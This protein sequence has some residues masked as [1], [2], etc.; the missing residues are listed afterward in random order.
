MVK[1]GIQS[2][3]SLVG[4]TAW[5]ER[6]QTIAERISKPTRS[7]KLAATRFAAECAIEKARRGLPLS[8]AD[9]AFVDLATRIPDLHDILAAKGKSRL[10][11]ALESA[12]IGDQTII[13][14]LHLIHTAE[15]QKSR[16]FEVEFSG[17]NEATPFDLLI[18]RD[19]AKAE[20]VCDTISAE[21][22]HAVHRGAWSS[23]IDRIDPD[24]QTWLSAHPGRYLLKMTLPQ[25][26]KPDTDCQ[27]LPILQARINQMLASASR[28]DFD[29]AAVLKLDPL[30]L[31]GAQASDGPVQQSTILAKLRREFGPEAHFSVTEAGQS[32][33]VMAA[34]G[35]SE[36]EVAGAVRRRMAAIA[37]ARLTGARPGIL[38]MMI[39]D[40]DQLEWR[41]LREQML[42]EG[43]ARQ[44]LTFP[45]GKTVIA[46]TCASRFELA[47]AGAVEGD[48]RF[49]NPM[50][51]DA[52]SAALAPAVLSTV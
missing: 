16:G 11:E 12:M 30:L 14:F 2:F 23:L 40:T 6:I 43:E 48:L 47:R 10:C 18:S 41:I 37:P 38:A 13:P 9:S 19:L 21:D 27:Y 34:R 35:S 33:F 15:L 17:F 49:R 7:S 20:I 52:K 36:N 3:V 42:L 44:F 45:E 25:G 4:N 8:Q 28:A 32:L 46:V 24:L 50:H 1:T 5:R 22:G 26:L 39:D 29:E 31:A 51:P